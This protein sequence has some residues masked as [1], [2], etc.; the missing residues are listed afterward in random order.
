MVNEMREG[1]C[2][3]PVAGVDPCSPDITKAHTIQRRGGLAAIAEKGHVM[4][5]KPSLKDM[6]ETD[7]NPEPKLVGVAKASIFP[8]FCNKHDTDLFRAIEGKTIVLDQEVA[9]LFAFRAIAYERFSKTTQL[10]IHELQ[11]DSDKGMPFHIQAAIQ[12][13]LATQIAGVKIG[14]EDVDRWKADYDTRLVSGD[15]SNFHFHAFRFDTV[16]PVVACGAFHPEYDFDG[17]AL[18]RLARRGFDFE[19]MAIIVTAFDA[20]TVAI[21]AWIGARDG[22][23]AKLASSFEALTED[24]KADALVRLLF[25]HTDNIFL[26]PSWW[27]AL[28]SDQRETFR[29]LVQ[30]GAPLVER[31]GSHLIDDGKSCVSA[32]VVEHVIG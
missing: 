27:N 15:R 10:R 16:L 7:G 5:V 22:P 9:F 32:T 13:L 24:R 17:N 20:Q 14:I 28:P 2:S 23:A 19:H 31:K 21:F 26:R 3:Y 12:T 18:Q 30:V 6:I 8:G 11:R 4:T 25:I 29:G 1:S